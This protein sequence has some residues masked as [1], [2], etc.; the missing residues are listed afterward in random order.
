MLSELIEQG[1]QN[2]PDVHI[3]QSR[4]NAALATAQLARADLGPQAGLSANAAQQRLRLNPQNRANQPIINTLLPNSG[5]ADERLNGDANVAGIGFVASWEPDIF[6]RKRSD[7][8]AAKAGAT[9]EQQN[10]YGAQMLLAA[11]IADAYLQARALQQHMQQNAQQIQHLNHLVRYLTGR[12]Q[13]GH[14]SA[15]ELDEARAA[16]QAIEAKRATLNAQYAQQ[17]REIAVL[18]GQVPQGFRLPES[19]IKVLD[20][21]PAAPEGQTPEGL[22]ERR[23]DIRARAAAIEAYAAKLASAKADYYPRFN[24]NFL[25]QNGRI[26]VGSDTAL[27]GW[28]NLLSVGLS[29][30]I[31]TSG[32]IKANVAAAD[33]RLKT[34]L[35]EYDQTVLRALADVDNAHHLHHDLSK[36]TQQ[37]QR[38]AHL[39]QKQ[40]HDAD[41]LFQYGHKTLDQALKA[42]LNADEAA[43][44]LTRAQL[45]QAQALLGLYKALGGGWS[46]ETN[47]DIKTN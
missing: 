42:H 37:L 34:A 38:S 12:F 18:I 39:Y 46:A 45:R 15:H 11:N 7:A 17:V 9:G 30:P 5:T 23:P 24:I 6:G 35:L 40:A 13:A 19:P 28:G 20:T 16:A 4:L 26:E 29:L 2:S 41:L 31:F 32:R 14:V 3:A 47:V 25:G 1:L 21:Q 8:D 44:N 43:E 36:Q 22:L 27:K 33:A 10:V